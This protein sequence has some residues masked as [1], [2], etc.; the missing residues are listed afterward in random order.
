MINHNKII[1]LGCVYYFL[2][3]GTGKFFFKSGGKQTCQ[4]L[5][6]HNSICSCCFICINIINQET[7]SFFQNCMYHIRLIIAINH[8][9]CNVHQAPC[10]RKRANHTC[11]HRSVFYKFYR[12]LNSVYINLGSSCSYFGDFQCFCLFFAVHNTSNN[13][14]NLIISKTHRRTK[15]LCLQRK[16]HHTD[17][18]QC[19]W[20]RICHYFHSFCLQVTGTYQFLYCNSHFLNSR[21]R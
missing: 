19:F 17:R 8:C 5:C 13:C 15:R 2:Y 14:R 4:R 11:K 12:F 20:C 18:S 6:H 7:G 16:I 3:I 9:L 10:Q 1:R 21:K